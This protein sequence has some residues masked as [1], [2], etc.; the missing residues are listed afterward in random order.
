MRVMKYDTIYNKE[1]IK[2]ILSVLG[3]SFLT[4]QVKSLSINLEI[5]E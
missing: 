2:K 4:F 3:I 1:D 5:E